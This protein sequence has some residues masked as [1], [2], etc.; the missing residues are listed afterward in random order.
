[1]QTSLATIQKQLDRYVAH[2]TRAKWQKQRI[3]E[4]KAEILRDPVKPRT[5]LIVTVYYKQKILGVRLRAGAL[6]YYGK[7]G[8]SLLDEHPANNR[9]LEEKVFDLLKS[10]QY[11]YSAKLVGPTDCGNSRETYVRGHVEEVRRYAEN[12]PRRSSSWM[13]VTN[14]GIRSDRRR[15][16]LAEVQRKTSHTLNA[17]RYRRD[18]LTYNN[19]GFSKSR[20]LL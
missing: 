14:V 6:K 8:R 12:M 11:S 13:V 7:V 16:D 4:M 3:E 9:F 1:M 17:E 19:L 2:L 10:P 15:S 20:F 5:N 18:N